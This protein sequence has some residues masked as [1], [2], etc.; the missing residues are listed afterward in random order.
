M[1]KDTSV[2]LL[3]PKV[4]KKEQKIQ[5]Y[6]IVHTSIREH[7][8][9]LDLMKPKASPTVTSALTAFNKIPNCSHMQNMTVEISPNEVQKTNKCGWD[10]SCSH[11]KIS[12]PLFLQ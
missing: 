12:Y 8:F 10:F 3:I 11:P 4:Y 1:L 2:P 7:V 5:K 9:T 6:S